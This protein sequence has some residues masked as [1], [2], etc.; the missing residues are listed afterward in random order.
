[1]K[2]LRFCFTGFLMMLALVACDVVPA[3]PMPTLAALQPA[4]TETY[5]GQ[6]TLGGTLT[7]SYPAGWS[8]LGNA[9]QLQLISDPSVSTAASLRPNTAGLTITTLPLALLGNLVPPGQNPDVGLVLAQFLERGD[10]PDVGSPVTGILGSSSV[11]RAQGSNT[12]GDVLALMIDRGRQ[13]VFI[14]AVTAPGELPQFLGLFEAIAA[15]T[16]YQPLQPGG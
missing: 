10:L 6:D 2:T 14:L 4:L 15:T 5:R 13:Y 9:D 12:Q 16:Q 3:A 8:V 1:M 7:L 11:A